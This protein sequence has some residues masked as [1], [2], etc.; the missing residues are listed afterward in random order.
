VLFAVWAVSAGVTAVV[1]FLPNIAKRMTPT[2]SPQVPAE[3]G[4]HV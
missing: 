1:G 2:A 3:S 4:A